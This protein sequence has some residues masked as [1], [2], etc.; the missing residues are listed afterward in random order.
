MLKLSSPAVVDG[1]LYVKYGIN[2]PDQSTV[3][4]GIPQV[5]FP[6]EWSGAPE[7]TKSYAVEYMDYDNA[8]DE[9]VIWIHWIAA[10]IGADK[11]G[12][13]ENAAK[14]DTSIIHGHNSWSLPYGPYEELSDEARIG[15]GGPAPGRRHTYEL[16]LYALDN[17][18]EL[19]TGFYYSDM[20]NAIE[21]HVLDKAV[22][23]MYYGE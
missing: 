3:K 6:V 18:P 14:E 2:T 21:G 12:L 13:L 4:E 19:E 8:E 11:N 7:G 22:L 5:S 16:V 9:G 15:Y 20:R 1:Y 10:G 17:V 23:K